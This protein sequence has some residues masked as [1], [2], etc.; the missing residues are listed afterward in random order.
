M[1]AFHAAYCVAPED[2]GALEQELSKFLQLGPMLVELQSSSRLRQLANCCRF[3][4]GFTFDCRTFSL[5]T[6]TTHA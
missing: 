6:A 1:S 5:H 2:A 3:I 4:Y